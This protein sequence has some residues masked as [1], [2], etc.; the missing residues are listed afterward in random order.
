M[1]KLLASCFLFFVSLNAFG[2]DC[3]HFKKNPIV[4]LSVPK[5]EV[6]ITQPAEYFGKTHGVIG[7]TLSTAYEME[8]ETQMVIGGECVILSSVDAEIGYT[9]F[10]IKM[11]PKLASGTC[12]YDAVLAHEMNH[13]HTYLSVVESERKNLQRSVSMSAGDIFPIFVKEGESIEAAIDG[14]RDKLRDNPRMRL[15]IQKMTAEQEIK[16]KKLDQDQST[17]LLSECR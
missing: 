15:A 7:T 13:L 9:G 12:E 17:K 1:K 4:N 5:Y 10:A 11:D 8:V 3:S 14:M 6:S 16:N 2:A